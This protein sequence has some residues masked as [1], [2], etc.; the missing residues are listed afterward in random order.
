MNQLHRID[1]HRTEMSR[2]AIRLVDGDHVANVLDTVVAG[3]T[4]FVRSADSHDNTSRESSSSPDSQAV[5]VVP[6]NDSLQ[7]RQNIRKFHKIAL[8]DLGVGEQIVRD[9]YVIG[10]ASHP[11]KRGDWVHIH[12]LKSQRA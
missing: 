7:A 1:N 4:V 2:Q 12:N 11:I 6:A 8:A 5:A 9:G 3:D 10:M